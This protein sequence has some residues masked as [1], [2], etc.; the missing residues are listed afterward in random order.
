MPKNV[1]SNCNIANKKINV[2]FGIEKVTE[3]ISAKF[4][5][6]NIISLSSDSIN[7]KKFVDVL[8]DIESAKIKIIVGTQIISKGFNFLNLNSIF[9]L[10]FDLWFYNTDIRIN[11]KIFQLT[12]Q[13]SGRTSRKSETGEVYIQTYDTN[14]YL[15]KYIVANDRN[16]FYEDELLKR[17]KIQLPPYCKLIAIILSCTDKSD[18]EIAS[19]TI[20]KKLL[21]FNN[22]KVLGPIP[23]PIEYINNKHRFR[24][25]IK[26][27]QPFYMQ[28]ILKSINLKKIS[29]NK[30]Y[31]KIDIDPLSFF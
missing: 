14:N 29:K 18:L 28:N 9:I 25:L 21:T 7:D 5:N 10:D 12:Q 3:E 6:V 31:I 11:E 8:K 26:T 23:A 22:L 4:N 17:K 2:G 16:K 24:M 27:N 30:V 20:K 13:V 1:C 15:L 19:N